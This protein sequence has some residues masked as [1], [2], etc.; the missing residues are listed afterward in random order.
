MTTSAATPSL[1]QGDIALPPD[2][3][4]VRPTCVL[5]ALED[6][7]RADAPS[8]SVVQ[9]RLVI[10]ELHAR[11]AIPFVLEVPA[12]ALDQRHLYSVRVHVDISGSGTVE[13]GDFITVQTYPV[14]T[15]G[16]G[17]TVHVTVRRV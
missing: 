15:R 4:S 12:G 3:L 10:G 16:Y 9:R 2:T 8:L 13:R 11:E 7:S 5:V 14:L 17:N 1:V 6:I